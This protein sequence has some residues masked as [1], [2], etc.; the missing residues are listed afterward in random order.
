[1]H[2][3]TARNDSEAPGDTKAPSVKV[4][5]L[6]W[7]L[8]AS[9]LGVSNQTLTAWRA[10]P[11]APTDT[12]PEAWEAFVREHGLGAKVE[13]G[14]ALAR[15]QKTE[16]ETELLKAKLAKEQRRVIDREEVSRLMLRIATEQ[17]SLLYQ[18][19]ETEL[20]PKCDGMTAGQMRPI[21]RDA[22]DAICEKMAPLVDQLLKQE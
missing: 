22:A 13:S 2:G 15:R 8:L 9:R 6:T 12:D 16:L 5:G 7:V 17:R 14:A 10:K 1:M 11:G 18:L 20:P 19:L 4:R 21:M 3:N